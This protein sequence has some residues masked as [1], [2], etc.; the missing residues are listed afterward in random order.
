MSNKP[1]VGPQ[2][3]TIPRNSSYAQQS[4][5]LNRLDSMVSSLAVQFIHYKAMP[6]P[7]GKGDKGDYRHDSESLDTISSNG[8]LYRKAGRFDACITDNSRGSKHVEG[9]ILDPSQSRLVMQ[10]KYLKD[11]LNPGDVMY[12][13]PG[14]RV[15]ISDPDADVLVSTFQEV[16]F[17]VGRDSVTMFPV[18]KVEM[19]IVDSQGIE[20]KENLDFIVSKNGDIRW[21][22]NANSK[23]PGISPTTGKGRVF[24]IRYLYKAYW[25]VSE[26]HKEIRITNITNGGVRSPTRMPFSLGIVREYMFHNTN[27]GD[28][29][30]PGKP[31]ESQRA[32]P[33]PVEQT[34][35]NKFQISVDLT[36]MEN[37]E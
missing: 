30:N 20:Y 28:S 31:K 1:P 18:V 33:A 4:F 24:S 32:V 22:N 16:D 36:A 2:I 3:D 12:F 5:D 35:P 6:S 21:L 17:E 11:D 34:N 19:P 13:S 10:R 27:R 25:Y 26:I 29:T 14:D 8:F 23:N 15:Y 7:I 9:G 37:D